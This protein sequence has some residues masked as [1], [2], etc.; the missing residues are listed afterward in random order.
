MMIYLSSKDLVD[1]VSP[2]ALV[3]AIEEG[4]RDFAKQTT[5]IPL[6]EHVYWDENTLLTMPAFGPDTFGVKIVSVVPSNRTRN[7]PVIN[8][9]M[10]LSDVQTGAPIAVL[11]A[12]M[13]TAQRTGALGAVGLKYTTPPD[14]DSVGVIGVGVQGTWQAIFA[15][16]VRRIN[17][18]YYI[19]R[20][21]K[22][23]Q[24][25]VDALARR[26][27]HVKP[28]RCLDAYELLSKTQV[29]ITATTSDEPVLPAER[30]LLENKHLVGIGSFKPS[31]KELPYAVCHS[32]GQV[33]VDSDAAKSEAGDL[34]EPLSLGLLREDDIIHI[35][36]L[37]VGKHSVDLERTTV[38]KSVGMALYDLYVARGVVAEA[39]RSGRGTPLNT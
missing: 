36:D 13:L 27:P 30:S 21:D 37:V 19:A 9:L 15:C 35:A 16:A 34:L 11:D 22:R 10:M 8:G 24:Q 14:A 23:A 25:F 2:T 31:M 29:I 28:S 39:R 32:S 6:R 26:V 18:V 12:A 7:L 20:S 3:G 1:L 38:F 5:V 33:V 17:T 4:L